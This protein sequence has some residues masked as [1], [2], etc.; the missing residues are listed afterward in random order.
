MPINFLRKK[1]PVVLVIVFLHVLVYGQVHDISVLIVSAISECP[2]V[3]AYALAAR[4]HEIWMLM[5]AQTNTY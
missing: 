5:K 3:C 4:M 2:E 1:E